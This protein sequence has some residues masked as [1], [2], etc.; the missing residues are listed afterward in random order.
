[1][2]DGDIFCYRLINKTK[3]TDLK[4][5]PQKGPVNFIFPA[6]IQIHMRLIALSMRYNRENIYRI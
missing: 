1:M 3:L 5:L 6:N 4:L 2:L